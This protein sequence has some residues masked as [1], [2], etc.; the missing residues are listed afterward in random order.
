MEG[1]QEQRNDGLTGQHVQEGKPDADRDENKGQPQP[2]LAGNGRL[3]L[4]PAM[5]LNGQPEENP[6]EQNKGGPH[7]QSDRHDLFHPKQ[8]LLPETWGPHLE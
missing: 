5:L 6:A 7:Q 3:A 1:M 2:D 4:F 8:F